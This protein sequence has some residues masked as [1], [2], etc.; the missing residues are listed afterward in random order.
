MRG[1]GSVENGA[2]RS[3]DTS[4]TGL[5]DGVCRIAVH[6]MMTGKK[7]REKERGQPLTFR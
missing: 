1:H 3:R 5:I 4:G 7:K 2:E 6:T